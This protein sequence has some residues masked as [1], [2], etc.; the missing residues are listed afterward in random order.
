MLNV[1]NLTGSAFADVLTGNRVDTTTPLDPAELIRLTYLG[2]ESAAWELGGLLG[3][4]VP[5][6]LRE[7]KERIVAVV[8]ERLIRHGLVPDGDAPQLLN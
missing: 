7:Q 2:D 3:V 8:R 5:A 1:E 4:D 6:D